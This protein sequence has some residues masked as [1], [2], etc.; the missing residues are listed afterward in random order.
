MQQQ[1]VEIESDKIIAMNRKLEVKNDDKQQKVTK[2][3]CM[4]GKEQAS[5]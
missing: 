5:A 2:N 3:C 1:A 4:K